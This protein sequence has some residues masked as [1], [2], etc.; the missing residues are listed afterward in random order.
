MNIYD[1][2]QAVNDNQSFFDAYNQFIFSDDRNTFNKLMWRL[3]FYD[4]TK[5]LTGNIVE[6][7]VF[8]G[9]GM[10]AFTKMLLMDEPNSI[11]KVIGFDRFNPSE[12]LDGL[13][14]NEHDLMEQV[15]ERAGDNI[16][17]DVSYKAVAERFAGAMIPDD[18][19]ELHQVDLSTSDLGKF[20]ADREG[21]RISLLYMDLDVYYPTFE[22]LAYL[23]DRVVDG[24]VVVFDEYGYDVWSESIAVDEFFTNKG[25]TIIQTGVKSPTAYLVRK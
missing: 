18:K 4:M 2:D 16:S 19:Y 12:V 13:H 1:K 15:F 11:K 5:H 20:L 24:G 10:M 7:G 21:F 3:R 22:T 14:G 23:W 8:K 9:S 17:A 6:C 25:Q